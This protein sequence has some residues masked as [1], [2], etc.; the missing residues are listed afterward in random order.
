MIIRLF[1]FAGLIILLPLVIL[2]GLLI[3]F[4]DG[5]PAIFKQK[6]LGKNMKEFTLYKIRTMRNEA[7]SRGTHEVSKN[8]NLH[9]GSFL[10]KLK[11][12]EF[13]Q[14]FN[15]IIG[16][17]N[18]FGS[19]PGLPNQIELKKFRESKGVFLSKP[20]ITGL[21]QVC[22]YDMSDPE[23]LSEI[24]ILYIQKCNLLLNIKILIATLTPLFRKDLKRFIIENI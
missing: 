13:P 17:M 10:R 24:D 23:K 3:Y 4:E 11:I 19:R 9:F 1:A 2:A 15:V 20:G 7:P 21:A 5:S 18:F 14:I 12:D 6:R 16:D 8:Y 22:G